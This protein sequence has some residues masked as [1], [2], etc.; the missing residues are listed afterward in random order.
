[1]CLQKCTLLSVLGPGLGNYESLSEGLFF[2]SFSHYGSYLTYFD[3]T[4]E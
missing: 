1:M 2:D 4:E 3:F